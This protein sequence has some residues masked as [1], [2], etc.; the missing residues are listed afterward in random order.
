MPSCL[1]KN[2]CSDWRSKPSSV[3]IWPSAPSSLEVIWN[4]DVWL[5]VVWMPK[6][7]NARLLPRISL[8]VML[9]VHCTTKILLGYLLPIAWIAHKLFEWNTP[10]S[11]SRLVYW[12]HNGACRSYSSRMNKGVDISA[13]V[14]TI[15]SCPPAFAPSLFSEK[16]ASEPLTVS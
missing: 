14:V 9:L 2:W 10:S 1:P 11:V 4:Y 8:P 7:C 12:R 16:F 5:P 15:A 3:R 6:D 13:R